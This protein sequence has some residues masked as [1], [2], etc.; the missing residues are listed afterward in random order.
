MMK[1]VSKGG[2]NRTTYKGVTDMAT[3]RI[4]IKAAILIGLLTALFNFA[5]FYVGVGIF[6]ET[7]LLFTNYL[8]MAVLSLAIGVFSFIFML[9]RMFYAAG[10]FTAG[11]LVGSAFML[12]TFWKGVAGWEDII[13]LLSFFVF[14]G[15]GLVTGLLVQLIVFLVNKSRKA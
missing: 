10:L 11:L 3:K 5:V 15:I 9:F 6:L 13:G 12:S 14:L 4:N 2:E 8:A 1:P 7:P